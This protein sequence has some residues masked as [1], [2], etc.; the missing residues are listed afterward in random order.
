MPTFKKQ[1]TLDNMPADFAE[2][3][4]HAQEVANSLIDQVRSPKTELTDVG[5][6]YVIPG[7][8]KPPVK[9]GQGELW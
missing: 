2:G 5:E 6:Q 4:R 3:L 8:E 7:A 1:V 9:R